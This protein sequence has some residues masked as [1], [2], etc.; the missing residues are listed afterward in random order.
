MQVSDPCAQ[1]TI[2]VMMMKW[3]KLDW[4][5]MQLIIL[6]NL[7]D[8]KPI[9]LMNGTNRCSGRVEVY[10]DGQWGTVCDDRWGMQEAAVACREMNCGVPLSVK[11]KAFFGRGQDQVWLDDV[12]CT[13]H[14]KSLAECPHR[15][16]GE[17]DCDHHED[18][19]LVCSGNTCCTLLFCQNQCF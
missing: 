5:N 17:H 7:T 19:G 16:F 3:T 2:W 10:H 9:R 14:E 18:A 4:I 1:T 12:E 15:G 6:F 11:Y 8:S 13:G